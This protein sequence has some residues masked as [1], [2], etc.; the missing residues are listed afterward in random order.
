MKI[1]STTKV[2]GLI[3]HPVKHSL[4]PLIHN[5]SFE[6]LNFNGVYVV[7]DVAPELLENAVKG[8]KALGIKGF[9]VTVPHKE[10]VMN[11]LDFVTEEAEKIGAVNTVVNENGILKG[12]N[13][14]VQGFIDSL[15]ELKEDVR[16]RKAFVLGAGGAS[17]AI[18]FAL[19][20]EGVESIVIANRTL[21]KARALAE[22]IREEFKVKCD[23]CSIEEVEK[24]NEI[25]ILINTTSVGMHP[26]VANSPVSEEVVA[27]ANF[28]YDL[29]YNPSETLFLKYARKNGVKSANGLSMLVNQASYAF[30]LWTGEFFDKDFVYEKIR[31]EI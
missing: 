25:D 27:K 16:G 5:S 21:N 28:V 26:E 11:Y 2:F 14:D 20:R 8:L 31:G 13:T 22:Y 7:F 30:Y 4:S 24:F 9:N 18:C 1:D 19:A 6:K 3:G 29:I 23:Y 10:S 12:Y 15:K 17:K